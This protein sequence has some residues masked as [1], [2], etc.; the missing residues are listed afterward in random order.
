[1]SIGGEEGLV[2]A[3]LSAEA[4]G[5]WLFSRLMK[6]LKTGGWRGA[7]PSSPGSTRDLLE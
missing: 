6:G 4:P 1:V 3:Y 2:V 7:Y 5:L